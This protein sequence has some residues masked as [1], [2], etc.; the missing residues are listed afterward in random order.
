MNQKMATKIHYD[1]EGNISILK[2]KIIGMIGYGNQGRSQALNMK[3][4]GLNVIVGNR[5]D[6]YKKRAENDGVKTYSIPE[7]VKIADILFLLIPDEVMDDV[8]KKNILPHLKENQALVFASGYNIAFKLIIPPEFIDTLLI[9]PRMIGI[10]VRERYL[11]LKG[12]FSF[13]GV[14]QDASGKAYEILL[15]LSKALGT[16]KLGGIE[17]TFMEEA[18]LDLFTEQGYGPPFGQFLLRTMNTL[19]DA[20]YPLEAVLVELVLSGQMK[21]LYHK[22]A[23]LGITKYVQS[24][25]RR[26]QYGKLSRAIKFQNITE[27]IFNI[28]NKIRNHI[29]N[30]GFAEEWEKKITKL[31][32]K[33]IKFFASRIGFGKLEK[34]VRRSLE[35]P[36][37]DLWAEVPYPSKVDI[38]ISESIR[39]ELKDFKDFMR[40]Y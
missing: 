39:K 32:F 25:P 6:Q 31:K 24:L 17:T 35:M 12:Y 2:D 16:L 27:E 4:S 36:E 26:A 20:G 37:L 5:D 34:K 18:V 3:D 40:E 11:N 23:E 8:Y 28:Q 33:V 38:E 30:G 15:A 14:D 29:E 13:I 7:A 9:A 21:Y 22:I 19:I 1:N 10:G